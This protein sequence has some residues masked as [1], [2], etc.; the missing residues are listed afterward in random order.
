MVTLPVWP[1]RNADWK[2]YSEMNSKTWLINVMLLGVVFFLGAKVYGIWSHGVAKLEKVA[3]FKTDLRHDI[4]VSEMV[5]RKSLLPESAYE[6]LVKKDLFVPQRQVPDDESARTDTDLKKIPAFSR[7]TYLYGVV[8]MKG[9]R[10]ALVTNLNGK[11]GK[12][13]EVWVHVGDALGDFT[14]SQ[15]EKE[16]IVLEEN[17]KTYDVLLFDK[18]KPRRRVIIQKPRAPRVLTSGKEM[19]KAK[20]KTSEL[21]TSQKIRPKTAK[22]PLRRVKREKK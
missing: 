1:E 10:A 17:K 6:V 9:E 19:Q 2:A 14:V 7:K 8:F 21:K 5:K 12:M 13:K 3:N 4:A 15:I 11:P 16:K 22:V 18:D 20:P